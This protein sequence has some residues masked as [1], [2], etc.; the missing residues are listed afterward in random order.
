MLNYFSVNIE[1]VLAF[2]AGQPRVAAPDPVRD[3]ALA[4]QLLRAAK[5]QPKAILKRDVKAGV[6]LELKLA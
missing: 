5:R 4:N 3:M 1:R 6:N 2:V